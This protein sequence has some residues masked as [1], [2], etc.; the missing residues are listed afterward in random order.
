ML[1]EFTPLEFETDEKAL[2]IYVV[3]IIRIYSVGVWNKAAW[4]SCGKHWNL[5]EFTPL[6]FETDPAGSFVAR[7]ELEF[8]PLEFETLLGFCDEVRPISLEF[9]PLEFETCYL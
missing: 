8:T 9:T 4:R 2:S 5:L 7:L 6:E 1:L 3:I